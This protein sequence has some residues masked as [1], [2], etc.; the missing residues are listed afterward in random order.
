[1]YLTAHFGTGC[2]RVFDTYL[3]RIR[4]TR[5]VSWGWGVHEVHSG[6]FKPTVVSCLDFVSMEFI[7][8][9]RACCGGNFDIESAGFEMHA[10]QSKG[11]NEVH[12]GCSALTFTSCLDSRR[13]ECIVPIKTCHGRKFHTDSNGHEMRGNGAAVCMKST[14]GVGT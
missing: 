14:R 9:I 8:R 5:R 10:E 3:G 1:M 12:T 13:M 4:N 2:G 11:A 6:C 7:A